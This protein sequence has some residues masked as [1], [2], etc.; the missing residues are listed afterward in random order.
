VDNERRRTR[1]GI[2][3]RF[4]SK[5]T[6]TKSVKPL[7]EVIPD[8]TSEIKAIL[9]ELTKVI[10]SGGP[11]TSAATVHTALVFAVDMFCETTDTPIEEFC[12][13]LRALRAKRDQS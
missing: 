6:G 1:E 7:M 5:H 12:G 9:A 13:N 2:A 10:C 11:G 8:P 3:A 4:R